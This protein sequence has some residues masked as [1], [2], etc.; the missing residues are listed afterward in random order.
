MCA[1]LPLCVETTVFLYKPEEQSNQKENVM[2]S[3]VRSLVKLL[4][5]KRNQVI[6]LHLAKTWSSRTT[7]ETVEFLVKTKMAQ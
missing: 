2:N 5:E 1:K 4:E 6:S 7:L 3:K